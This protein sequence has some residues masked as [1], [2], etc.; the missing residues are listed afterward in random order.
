MPLVMAAE[1]GLASCIPL[2]RTPNNP[3]GCVWITSP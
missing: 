2:Q 3:V 1:A